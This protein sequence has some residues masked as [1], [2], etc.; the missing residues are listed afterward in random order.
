MDPVG[1]EATAEELR[2]QAA[3]AQRHYDTAVGDAVAQGRDLT[4]DEEGLIQDL[5]EAASTAWKRYGTALAAEKAKVP[6]ENSDAGADH[7][8]AGTYAPELPDA[9]VP[10]NWGKIAGDADSGVKADAQFDA[11]DPSHMKF[12]P[13]PP[14]PPARINPYVGVGYSGTVHIISQGA[15]SGAGV[16]V[17]WDSLDPHAYAKG[18]GHFGPGLNAAH[19]WELTVGLSADKAEGFAYGAYVDLGA[20]YEF[21]GGVTTA[22]GTWRTLS[23]SLSIGPGLGVSAGATGAYTLVYPPV[24]PAPPSSGPAPKGAP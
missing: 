5:G 19:G 2:V 7:P 22:D 11:A 9:S 24:R 17:D 21:G 12:V 10:S 6:Y 15:A 20:L 23:A 4:A 3:D 14:A 1:L 8:C 18:E 16:F 13:R